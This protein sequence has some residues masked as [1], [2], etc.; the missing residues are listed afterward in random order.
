MPISAAISAAIAG[1]LPVSFAVVTTQV[2]KVSGG[3]AADQFFHPV[4]EHPCR[5]GIAGI[6][7]VICRHI[8]TC[9]SISGCACLK[10][11]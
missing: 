4:G 1:V 9:A 10:L 6:A 8:L 5:T 2:G 11:V 7:L 3:Q